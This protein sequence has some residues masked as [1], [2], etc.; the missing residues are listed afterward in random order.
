MGTQDTV[1]HRRA[2]THFERT[3]ITREGFATGMGIATATL[4]AAV[5]LGNIWK[6]PFLTG[7]NGGVAFL[8]V[9]LL[10]TLLIGLPIMIS[11]ILLG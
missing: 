1:A 5:G 11:E 8:L 10:S 2:T 4:G 7:A 9:Y 6:F 3:P